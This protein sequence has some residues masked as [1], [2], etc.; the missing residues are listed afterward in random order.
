MTNMTEFDRI[1]NVYEHREER[2]RH[3]FIERMEQKLRFK[4]SIYKD[5]RRQLSRFLSS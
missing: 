4:E 2:K 5:H 1:I 3:Q